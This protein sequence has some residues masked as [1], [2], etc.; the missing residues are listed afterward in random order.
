LTKGFKVVR[1]F[2]D[3]SNTQLKTKKCELLRIGNDDFT[4]FEI[5]NMQTCEKNVLNSEANMKI[6]RYL[7]APLGKGK[8]TKMKWCEK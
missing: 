3:E 1:D 2:V 7:G 5:N 4:A 8:V 6:M